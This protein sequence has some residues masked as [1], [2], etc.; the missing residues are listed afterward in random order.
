MLLRGFGVLSVLLAFKLRYWGFMCAFWYFGCWLCLVSLGILGSG[1]R[2]CLLG[3]FGF[4]LGI[5][6]FRVL[7]EVRLGVIGLYTLL[8]W[9]ALRIALDVGLAVT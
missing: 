4:G 7:L 3:W 9:S 5:R 6:L 2:C 1:F 8:V